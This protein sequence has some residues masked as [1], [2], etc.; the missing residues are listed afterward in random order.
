MVLKKNSR[1]KKVET[2]IDERIKASGYYMIIFFIL[3]IIIDRITKIWASTLASEIDYGMF[4][5]TYVTNTGAGFSILQ[6]QNML[7]LWMAIVALGLIIYFYNEFPKTGFV[8]I[9][10]GLIGNLIDRISYG[11]VVDFINFKFWPI[12]NAADAFI[13]IGVIITIILI[14]IKEKN[15]NTR[16]LKNPI[17]K[18]IKRRRK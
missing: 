11:S 7:L 2:Y 5:F 12:F 17:K 18:K 1:K 4:A 8:L 13:F 6:N 9:T 3:L 10:A 14:I 15:T 16:V